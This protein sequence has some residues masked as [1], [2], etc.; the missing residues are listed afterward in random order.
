MIAAVLALVLVKGTVTIGPLTP[1]CRV[2]TPC[3]GPAPRVVLTFVSGTRTFRA[4]TG[5]AGTYAV[6]LAPGSY[7][8]T[9]SKGMRISPSVVVIRSGPR[10]Q[11]FAID[12]GIR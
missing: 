9:A 6:R 5:A 2:G 4:T 3:D 8:V 12:T 7:T 11:S 1:V 10:R